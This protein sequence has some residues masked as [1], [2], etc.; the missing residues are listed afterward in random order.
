MPATASSMIG[1]AMF[2]GIANP[3][4]SAPVAIAVLMPMTFPPASRSAP[5]LLPGLIAAS[6]WMRF[7]MTS[8]ESSVIRRPSADTMPAVTLFV[9]VPSGL[10]IAIA[11]WPTL[12]LDE[13]PNVATGSPVASTFTIARSESVS[14]PYTLPVNSRPSFRRTLSWSAPVTTWPFV[15]IQPSAL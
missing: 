1:L 7:R 5:P 9:Y 10:P 6:V 13:S 3:R 8:P 2:T 14:T 15:R 11:S 4:P 12:T